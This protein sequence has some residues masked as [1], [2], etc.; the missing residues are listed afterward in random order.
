MINRPTGGT[1]S[2]GGGNNKNGT[3]RPAAPP[4][5]AGQSPQEFV[6]GVVLEMRRVTWPTRQEWISATILTIVLVVSIGLFTYL[7]DQAFGWI[8]SQI[9]PGGSA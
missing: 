4:R 5:R 9:H 6:R 7:V 2:R 1:T 8:F 3:G